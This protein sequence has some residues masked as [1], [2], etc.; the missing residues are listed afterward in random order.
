MKFCDRRTM[1]EQCYSKSGAQ[2]RL[3]TVTGLDNTEIESKQKY[4]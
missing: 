1:L 2:P 4:L 3:K